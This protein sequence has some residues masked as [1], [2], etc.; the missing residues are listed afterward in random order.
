M[1]IKGFIEFFK[2]KGAFI[3]NKSLALL[4]SFLI[5]ITGTL[6]G[7]NSINSKS[8]NN[9]GKSTKVEEKSKKES[10]I[11]KNTGDNNEDT[12]DEGKKKLSLDAIEV[13]EGQAYSSK[14]EVAAYIYKF[15]KLPK[16]Y[17]KKNDAM[18][19]G[20]DQSSGNLWKVT[21]KKS[22]GGDNFGNFEGKLPKGNGIKYYECDIDYEGGRRNAKR[23][24]FSNKGDI[25]YTEDHYNNFEKLN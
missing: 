19:L 16:N 1:D 20:W 23:I 18:K 6:V 5:I 4:L 7:C 13:K 22:I 2:G 15:K 21:D 8:T 9:V 10:G 24:V 14:M 12:K 17:I 3:K 11:T 25:Y